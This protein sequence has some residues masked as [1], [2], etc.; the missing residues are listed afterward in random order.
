MGI[1]TKLRFLIYTGW[2]KPILLS[3]CL[4][5]ATGFYAFWPLAQEIRALHENRMTSND[6]ALS[7]ESQKQTSLAEKRAM[8]YVKK[9]EPS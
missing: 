3:G 5:V 8:D 9:T 6:G 2:A 7:P 4:G 1:R